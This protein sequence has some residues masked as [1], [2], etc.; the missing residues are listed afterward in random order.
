MSPLLYPLVTDKE[1][2]YVP[3]PLQT[4][5]GVHEAVTVTSI[6]HFSAGVATP[7]SI[8]QS[9]ITGLSIFFLRCE[10]CCKPSALASGNVKTHHGHTHSMIAHQPPERDLKPSLL[11]PQNMP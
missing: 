5:A 8:P 7:W 6:C 1:L 4:S 3:I 11:D 2:D 9:S 10:D